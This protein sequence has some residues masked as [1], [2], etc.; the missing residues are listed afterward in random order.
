MPDLD[1][2]FKNIFL[3]KINHVLTRIS[4]FFIHIMIS[5]KLILLIKNN[6]KLLLFEYLTPGIREDII[7]RLVYFFAGKKCKVFCL[8]HLT[9]RKLSLI[10]SEKIIQRRMRFVDGIITLGSSLSFYLKSI[11]DKPTATLLHYA[12]LQFYY[13]KDR[14]HNA[15]L[16]VLILGQQERDY[17][18]LIEFVSC[19]V[20]VNYHIII[21]NQSIIDRLNLFKNVKCYCGIDEAE[22]VQIMDKCEVSL[23]FMLDVVGSN[24][25]S[26]C[27]SKGIVS[28]VS[29]LGSIRDYL[30]E[31]DTLFCQ[32]FS[33]FSLNLKRI[34]E[35]RILLKEFRENLIMK[36]SLLSVKLFENALNN[37]IDN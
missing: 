25:I 14:E 8:V 36:R 31:K 19:N 7:A 35:N 24:V 12:D 17:E 9:P 16:N 2:G 4:L 6:D 26:T 18:R 11:L 34:N 32:T 37:F 20:Y 5:F 21:S 28:I 13:L 29:D 23:N 30:S 15:V 3:K 33:D 22:L 27:I 1:L 10:Y